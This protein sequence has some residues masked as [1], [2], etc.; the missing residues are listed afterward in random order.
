MD[1]NPSMSILFRPIGG[2]IRA[3]GLDDGQLRISTDLNHSH[4]CHEKSDG[5]YWI[6]PYRTDLGSF[7]VG[8]PPWRRGEAN[9]GFT[10]KLAIL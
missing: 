2:Q 6:S 8:N 1:R 3:D 7:P 9:L 5:L 10:I 4:E